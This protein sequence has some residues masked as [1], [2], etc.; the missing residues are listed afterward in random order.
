[1]YICIYKYRSYTKESCIRV[2]CADM[3]HTYSIKKI[4]R[5]QEED[6]AEGICCIAV[7]NF[8]IFAEGICCIAV[9]NFLI[10]AVLHCGI[11]STYSA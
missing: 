7:L 5:R 9:L 6:Y 8:F 1:M 2:M 11:V 4:R 10:F 3:E